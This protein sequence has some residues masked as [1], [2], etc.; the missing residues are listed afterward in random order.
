MRKQRH[1]KGG[2]IIETKSAL[3]ITK[4][5]IIFMLKVNTHDEDITEI[6]RGERRQIKTYQ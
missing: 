3:N 4:K 6:T 5:D 2:R 1:K